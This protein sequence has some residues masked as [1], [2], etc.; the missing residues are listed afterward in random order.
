MHLSVKKTKFCDSFRHIF[1]LTHKKK[2]I[3]SSIFVLSDIMF[4]LE[5]SKVQFF[6]SSHGTQHIFFVLSHIQFSVIYFY[7]RISC[8]FLEVSKVYF[9][10][11]RPTIHNIYIFKTFFRLVLWNTILFF[12]AESALEI[13]TKGNKWQKIVK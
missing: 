5:V 4:F 12:S 9:F 8:F 10:F 2:K 11:R 3:K 1:D 7:F 13:W 6:S